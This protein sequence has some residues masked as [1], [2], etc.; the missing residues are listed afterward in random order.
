MKIYNV[1]LLV[2]EFTFKFNLY[3]YDKHS[4]DFVHADADDEGTKRALTALMRELGER[5]HDVE[6]LWGEIRGV[7]VRTVLPIQPHLAHVYNA[8]VTN[9]PGGGGGGGGG[10]GEG[11][12]GGWSSGGGRSWGGS[13]GGDSSDGGGS[14]GSGGGGGAGGGS[15]GGGGG[16]CGS[17][18]GGSCHPRSTDRA[19][20]RCFEL[21]GFDVMLDEA[22][23][24]WLL[25]VGLA[26]FTLF[27]SQNTN[28]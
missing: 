23:R 18:G 21:L 11:G 8:A 16:G 15:G 1:I 4:D 19:Q 17:G 26:L 20:S 5:G 13:S 14:G 9:G 25:E 6:A 10:G 27:C 22:L 3:R 7:I 12:G 28:L 2:S 24:P